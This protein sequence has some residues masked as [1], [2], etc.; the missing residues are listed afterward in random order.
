LILTA[1]AAL[2]AAGC[3]TT[4]TVS[5]HVEHGLD[6][7]GYRTYDWGAPDALPAGDPRFAENAIFRDR[8]EGAVEKGLAARGLERATGPADLLIHYHATVTH[9]LAVE[10]YGGAVAPCTG[11]DCGGRLVGFEEGTLVLDVVDARTNRVIWRGWAQDRLHHMLGTS[12]GMAR[13]INVAVNRMLERLPLHV[14]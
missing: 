4:M 8:L 12:D 3:A 5:S 10:R 2:A 6:A 9:R 14:E 11:D 7:S 13:S 1:T